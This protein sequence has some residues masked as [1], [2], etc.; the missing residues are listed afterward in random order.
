MAVL[1]QRSGE[2]VPLVAKGSVMPRKTRG[3]TTPIFVE[4]ARSLRREP[5]DS[6]ALLWQAL[7]NQSIASLKFRRQHPVG[8]YVL[9]FYCP[10]LK[11]GI[12]VDGEIHKQPEQVL[13]D[14]QRTKALNNLGIYVLRFTNAEIVEDIDQVIEKILDFIEA[15]KQGSLLKYPLFATKCLLDLS[16]N[17]AKCASASKD[18]PSPEHRAT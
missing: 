16:Q 13:L 17:R 1:T 14:T 7:R 6:E 18:T 15:K 4:A 12:E 2:G 11:L 3:S 9:D 8:N 5:T 10:K